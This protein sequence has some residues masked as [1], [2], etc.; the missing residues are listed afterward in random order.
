MSRSKY[1]GRVWYGGYLVYLRQIF[2]KINF[3]L[4]LEVLRWLIKKRIKS[5]ENKKEV[6]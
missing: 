4:G 2:C 5:I 6:E 3:V 1:C